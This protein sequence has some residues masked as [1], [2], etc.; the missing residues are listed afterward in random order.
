MINYFKIFSLK[1]EFAIDLSEL[2]E[3]YLKLQS[4]FHPDKSSVAEIE[5]SML[6]NEA[7]K[8]LCD[9]FLRACHILSLNDID[10]IND[11]KAVRVDMATLEEILKLQ[12]KIAEISNLD[13]ITKLQSGINL[14]IKSLITKAVE[15]FTAND[16]K[17]AAQFLV[18]AKYLKKS[19]S[20]LKERK[21][22][23]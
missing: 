21:R 9:D 20:D 12:E 16:F 23:I 17:V 6:I 22:K 8:I 18:K 2:E 10:L 4:Q 11:E 1:E 13:E 3:K 14:E 19:L 15:Y 5:K 7:Y